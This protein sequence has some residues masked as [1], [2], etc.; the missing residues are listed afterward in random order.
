MIQLPSNPCV[1][2]ERLAI[3][4]TFLALSTLYGQPRS[5]PVDPAFLRLTYLYGRILPDESPFLNSLDSDGDPFKNTRSVVLEYGWQT[6]GSKPW[7]LANKYPRYGVGVHFLHILK[8][9]ELGNPFALYGFTEGN[10]GTWG[11]VNVT[12]YASLGIAAGVKIYNPK[13]SFPN[14][15]FATHLNLFSEV[16]AG[17]S[18]S[19]GRHFTLQPGFRLSHISNGNTREPQ[20]GM[21]VLSWL[22]GLRFTPRNYSYQNPPFENE[23]NNVL[24]RN[25]IYGFAGFST[26]QIEFTYSDKDWPPPTYGWNFPMLNVFLGYNRIVNMRFK[27][28]GGLDLFYDGTAGVKD[29]VQKGVENKNA[30]PFGQKLGAS[31]FVLGENS[32][33]RLSI[34]GGLGYVVAR[35]A[36]QYA[37]PRLEQ[38]L[39]VKYHVSRSMFLGLNVRAYN[40]SAAKALELNVGW[41]NLY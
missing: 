24:H 8:R 31:L 16:G 15:I 19:I 26:R 20:K 29:A 22:M 33:D 37:T 39:G 17:V 36:F 14:D 34:Y 11:P 2:S 18:F 25:E 21:N 35:K 41:R 4:L 23:R 30:I 7:H 13:D 6:C 27:Y 28:G 12:T 3:F 5:A 40:F 9:Q 10:L 1:L 32:I 38:R